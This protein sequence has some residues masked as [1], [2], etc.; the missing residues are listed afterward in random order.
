MNTFAKLTVW[1]LV[2]V[3]MVSE[4]LHLGVIACPMRC[5]CSVLRSKPGEAPERT[6]R[7]RRVMCSNSGLDGPIDASV[8]PADTVHLDL[9]GNVI[10]I[11]RTGVFSGLHLLERLDLSHNRIS[12]IQPG[13]FEGL[14]S[15]R[16]L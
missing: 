16:R 12:I 10:S 2:V 15:L 8:M 7:G 1:I 9:S 14:T 3:V 4:T 13:A 6:P 11:L 5:T